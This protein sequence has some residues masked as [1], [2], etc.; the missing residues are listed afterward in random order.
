VTVTTKQTARGSRRRQQ[1]LESA[2]ELMADRGYS[3]VSLADIG[4]AAGIVG[5]GIYRHFESKSAILNALLDVAMKR[6][7]TATRE[8]VESDLDGFDLLA[9]MIRCQAEIVVDDR[10]LIAV[11][12]KDSSHV[13]QANLRQLRR[14]QRQLVEEW[15]YQCEAVAP[16][17]GEAQIR[18]TVHGVLALINSIADHVSVLSKEQMVESV[19]VMAVAAL[20]AGLAIDH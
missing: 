6:M 1:I 20:R 16:G 4:G 9:A 19:T 5:S 15:L 14:Q 12:L 8:M 10:H 7:L 13:E 3:A 2:A 18:A 17:I 11:Y